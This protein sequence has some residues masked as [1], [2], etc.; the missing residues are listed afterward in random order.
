MKEKISILIVEDEFLAALVLKRN[1]KLLGYEVCELVATGEEAIESAAKE[2]PDIILMDIRLAG[3][4]DGL[5]AAQEIISRY[6]V[7]IIFITGYSDEDLMERAKKLNPGAYLI[8]PVHMPE[9]E[10]AID[11]IFDENEGRKPT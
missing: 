7:P 11:S 10:S 5:E 2:K 4:M 8:K 6:K 3:E 9:L 1:L